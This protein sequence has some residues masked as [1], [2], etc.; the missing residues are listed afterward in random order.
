MS[1]PI[2][3]KSNNMRKVDISSIS[4]K[5]NRNRPI[6]VEAYSQ[7]QDSLIGRNYPFAQRI[8]LLATSMQEA[9]PGSYGVG[10]GGYLGLS[11]NRMPTSYLGNTPSERAKQITYVLNDLETPHSDNW[12]DGGS[13]G[14]T[15]KSGKDGY[16]MFWN[17][18]DVDSATQ[19]LNKSYVR[20]AGRKASWD[21]RSK[22]AKILESKAK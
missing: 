18:N 17:T 13:G 12:L 2:F 7:F 19:I 11:S 4:P 14:I 6:D 21:N 3:N 10:G 5:D 8:A 20:P 22:L 1:F 16:N 15:I 9:S